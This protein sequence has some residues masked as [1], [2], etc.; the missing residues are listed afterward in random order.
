[1]NEESENAILRIN[2]GASR[3]A[4]S[5]APVEARSEWRLQILPV[6]I[7]TTLLV[8]MLSAAVCHAV[9]QNMKHILL[10][11]P[12]LEDERLTC[13]GFCLLDLLSVASCAMI[14]GSSAPEVCIHLRGRFSCDLFPLM[15]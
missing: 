1:M 9:R 2:D 5:A 12:G 4:G 13:F 15:L 3:V 6:S 14:R 8:T 10:C 7:I 11:C